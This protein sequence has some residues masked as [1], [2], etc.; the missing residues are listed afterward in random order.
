M[1]LDGFRRDQRGFGLPAFGLAACAI[2]MLAILGAHHLDR[3]GRDGTLGR[4]AS[5][6]GPGVATA[7]V[8]RDIDLTPTGSINRV[9]LDPCT[10][11]ALPSG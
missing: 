11:K 7:P 5:I 4:V 10:G 6:T 3:L 2:T 1:G 8:F 9:R